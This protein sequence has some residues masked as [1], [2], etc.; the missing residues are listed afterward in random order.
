MPQKLKQYLN[1]SVLVSIPALVEG[2]KCRA[3]TLKSIED[4][5]LWLSSDKLAARLLPEPERT[6]SA[7]TRAAWQEA[8]LDIDSAEN[9]MW[10]HRVTCTYPSGS[11]TEAS[12]KYGILH[13]KANSY[14]TGVV[15]AVI[16][17]LEAMMMQGSR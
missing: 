4:D 1:R 13:P 6:A 5:G 17:N 14:N 8:G 11:I 12:S 9:G 2:G 7:A 16:D 10:R 3:C 15:L